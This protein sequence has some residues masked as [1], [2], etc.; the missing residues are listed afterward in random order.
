MLILLTLA[1]LKLEKSNEVKEEQLENMKSIFINLLVL[2][3]AKFNEV[4][5]EHPENI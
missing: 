3:L 2:K 4:K 5:E 1:I